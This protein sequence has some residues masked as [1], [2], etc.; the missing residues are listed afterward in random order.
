M[1]LI[2]LADYAIHLFLLGDNNNNNHHHHQHDHLFFDTDDIVSL[3]ATHSAAGLQK[4]VRGHKNASESCTHCV[5][6]VS[7]M[8]V[9]PHDY[10]H[11]HIRAAHGHKPALFGVGCS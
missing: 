4:S 8:L 3:L 1:H 9:K 7:K 11:G 5:S 6:I 2:H 10:I